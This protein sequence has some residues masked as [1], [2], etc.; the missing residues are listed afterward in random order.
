M[1]ANPGAGTWGGSLAAK[2]AADA[3]TYKITP[4]LGSSRARHSEAMELLWLRLDTTHN[5]ALFAKAGSE[6]TVTWHLEAP[7]PVDRGELVEIGRLAVLA[8]VR[9]VCRRAPELEFDWFAVSPSAT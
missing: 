1:T 2:D 3:V 4:H 7:P 8:V 5:Q 9:E 6:V